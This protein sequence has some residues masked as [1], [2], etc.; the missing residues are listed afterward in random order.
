MASPRRIVTLLHLW[1]G[2]SLGGLM[3]LA[4]LSGA[5]L[6]FYV[7]I[8]G[9]LHPQQN[10][11]GTAGP[12]S[13]DAALATL[14]ETYPDKTGPWRL[15][16]TGRPGAIPARYYN[17]PE[18]AG[19]EFAPMMVWLAPD[20]SAV[21]RR[22]YWGDYAMTWIYDLH[23]RLQMGKT[24]AKVLGYASLGLVVLIMTGLVAWWP[25]GAL[26][27]ALRVRLGASPIRRLRDIHKIAGLT[28][29]AALLVLTVTG[30]MLALPDETRVVLSRAVGPV[31][32]APSPSSRRLSGPQ[33][34]P[35]QAMA[36]AHA[37]LPSARIAW[38]EA[39]GEGGAPFRIRMQVSGDPSRRFPHSYVW[40]DQH[41]ARTLAV[42]DIRNLGAGSVVLSWLH[43]LHDGSAGGTG[44]RLAWALLG[45]T[46]TL[47]LVTGVWRWRLRRRQSGETKRL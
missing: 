38:V 26:S 13:Y 15:E 4:G 33:I 44:L 36:A 11:P 35:S 37:A 43:P 7:E 42:S 12:A 28:G 46:P 14:R 22:D 31:H 32:Q 6:V 34:L 21:L 39:P 18:T 41:D 24:G 17:P 3:A 29:F 2:L 25:R 8:D 20:G 40:I 19:R 16:I 5:I 1:L 47:L 23:Y 27:K 9:W 45:L 30:L 10:A